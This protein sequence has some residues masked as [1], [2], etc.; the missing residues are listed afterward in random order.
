MIRALL[1]GAAGIGCW[2]AGAG[3]GARAQAVEAGRMLLRPFVLPFLWRAVDDADHGGTPAEAFAR[4]RALCD[5]L[6]PWA[7]G[8]LWVAWRWA[9]GGQGDS[10]AHLR[11]LRTT[12]VWLEDVR[13][14]RPQ[15]AI[16][17]LLGSSFLVEM[18]AR[19]DEGLAERLPDPE[20]GL[21]RSA[22]EV[23][24]G[25]LQAAEAEGAGASVREQRLFAVPGLAAVLLR[26]GQTAAALDLLDHAI[27]RCASIRKPELRDEWRTQ[28]QR[29]RAA[30][31]REPGIQLEALRADPRLAPLWPLLPEGR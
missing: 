3:A 29:V 19:H 12:L 24:D 15:L 5:W 6:G 10:A 14:Q 27:E 9:E 1:L 18:A 2:A 23:V 4:G 25:L 26:R 7:D 28:L 30:L 17:L 8:Y 16:E 21:G 11:R 22:E 13:R 20:H 31:A